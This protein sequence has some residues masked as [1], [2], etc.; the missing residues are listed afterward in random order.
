MRVNDR[1]RLRRRFATHLDDRYGS[2]R[3]AVRRGVDKDQQ[4]ATVEQLVCQ[5]DAA[6]AD[7]DEPDAVGQR[8]IRETPSDLDTESVIGEEDV[9][10][11]GDE[12]MVP[13]ALSY[14]IRSLPLAHAR[15]RFAS[16]A[17]EAQAR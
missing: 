13:L 7:V 11:A 6:N 12:D 10:H 14:L 5:M 2:G 4:I 9:P 17:H 1:P 3:S 15:P 8:T 16:D